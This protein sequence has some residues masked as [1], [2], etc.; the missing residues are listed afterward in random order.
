MTDRRNQDNRL[1]MCKQLDEVRLLLMR[2]EFDPDLDTAFEKYMHLLDT[3]SLYGNYRWGYE[4][5]RR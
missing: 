3:L 2:M 1:E 4:R 5:V